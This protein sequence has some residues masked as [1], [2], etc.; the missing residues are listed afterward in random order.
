MSAE[1]VYCHITGAL[2][3]YVNHYQMC[4]CCCCTLLNVQPKKTLVYLW[5]IFMQLSNKT[6]T[7]L[8]FLL[9]LSSNYC[10]LSLYT[11]KRYF[12][13]DVVFR[14]FFFEP[15]AFK[16]MTTTVDGKFYDSNYSSKSTSSGKSLNRI[17]SLVFVFGTIFRCCFLCYPVPVPWP[18][19]AG[20]KFHSHDYSWLVFVKYSLDDYLS[21]IYIHIHNTLPMATMDKRHMEYIE[22]ARFML[23]TSH[24][25]NYIVS[26]V[27]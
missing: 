4:C 20:E 19:C 8:F 16:T 13:L 3:F 26:N 25:R 17:F 7:I 12:E 6:T 27:V 11:P 2:E 15:G 9:I 14:S 22:Y 1:N 23:S 18:R 10:T 21:C 5:L 24:F